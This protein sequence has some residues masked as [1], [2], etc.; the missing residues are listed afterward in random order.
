MDCSTPGFPVQGTHRQLLELAQT[1]VHWA[2]DAIQSFHLLSSSSP[3]AFN[4]PQHQGLFQ[5]VGSLYQGARV[6]EFQLQHQSFHWIFR[7]NFL[8]DRLV[9]SPCSPRDSQE[10]SPIL[11]SSA[12][13][14]VHFSHPYMTTGKTIALT[15]WTFAG[16]VMSLLFNM[17][18]RLVITFL[19][20]SKHLLIS[21]LQSRSAVILEPKKIKSFTVS[22]VSP[23]IYHEVMGSNTM[24]LVYWVLNF[25]PAFSLSPSTFIKRLFTVKFEFQKKSKCFNMYIYYCAC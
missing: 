23:S 4:L 17:Q 16:K 11:R 6:L 9:W 2:G 24:T 15:S 12:L 7:T 5:W 19:P 3:P 14:T 1:H 22:I 21:W 20:R 25:K 10:S 18:S 8:Y 13:F